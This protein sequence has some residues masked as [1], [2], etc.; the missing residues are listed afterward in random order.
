MI[1]ITAPNKKPLHVIKRPV[2]MSD[3][4]FEAVKGREIRAKFTRS[5]KRTY[6]ALK[7]E[8]P[9][10]WILNNVRVAVG[11]YRG[12]IRRDYSPYSVEVWD[13]IYCPSVRVIVLMWG[14]QSHKSTTVIAAIMYGYVKYPGPCMT[15]SPNETFARE[16]IKKK[17]KPAIKK[18][19]AIRR[20]MTGKE[21][22]LTMTSIGLKNLDH[23]FAYAGSPVSYSDRSILLLHIEEADK[24]TVDSKSKESGVMEYAKLRTLAYNKR[25]KIFVSCTPT[26]ENGN[27]YKEFKRCVKYV[28]KVPCPHCG[29]YIELKD[30]QVRW[31]KNSDGKSLYYQDILEQNLAWYECQKCKKE[32]NDVQKDSAVDKCRWVEPKTGL[33]MIDHIKRYNVRSIAPHLPTIYS[34]DVSCSMVASDFLKTQQLETHEER[35]EAMKNYYNFV[36][37]LPYKT[38]Y[39]SVEETRLKRLRSS[40]PSNIIPPGQVVSVLTCAIDT[41]VDHFVYEV[42]AWGFGN[43]FTSW[44]INH[45]V[46]ENFEELE[47]I[48]YSSY[49]DPNNLIYKVSLT[50]IDS[51]AGEGDDVETRTEQ[52]YNFARRNVGQVLAYKSEKGRKEYRYKYKKLDVYP[53]GKRPIPGGLVLVKG[54]KHY[55][56]TFMM[57][58]IAQI[59]ANTPGAWNLNADTTDEYLK[60][61]RNYGINK[62]RLW[63]KVKPKARVDY[64]DVGSMNCTA[65]EILRVHIVNG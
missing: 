4:M 45:G 29:V 30:E 32:I 58:K 43:H 41:Q 5:E 55:F 19:P 57:N 25:S 36:K 39:S 38:I 46:A 7:S 6:N 42:R 26:D 17:Y 24:C 23:Y 9:S 21:K 33:S 60:Q 37:S 20:L 16:A 52:V 11:P 47:S 15:L 12:L 34:P 62:N 31:P 63:E 53:D 2:W 8:Q 3:E 64:H 54:D 1:E 56:K 28:C 61:M 65:A 59:P 10:K 27:I 13:A 50:L 35:S 48:I 18:T 51:G 14:A 44:Q 40:L 22:D 49:K